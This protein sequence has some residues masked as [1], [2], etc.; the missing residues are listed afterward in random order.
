MRQNIYKKYNVLPVVN[1]AKVLPGTELYENVINNQLYLNKLEFKPNEI[2]TEEFDPKWVADQ[3]SKFRRELYRI[4]IIKSLTSK[5]E[6]IKSFQILIDKL[7]DK[8][9]LF[10]FNKNYSS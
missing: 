9:A 7:N 8:M 6:F 1:L 3:Y 10:L 4:R 2:T 5:R